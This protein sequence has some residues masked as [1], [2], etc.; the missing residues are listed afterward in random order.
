[1]SHPVPKP[2]MLPN[3][4]DVKSWISEHAVELHEHTLPKSFNFKLNEAGKAVMSYRNWSHEQWQGSMVIL[5][6]MGI[7]NLVPVC[8]F[9]V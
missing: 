2:F 1:M 8:K 6:V 5:N 9:E 4:Y 3:V 7:G